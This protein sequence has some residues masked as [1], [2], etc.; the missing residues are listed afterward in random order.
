MRPLR[1]LY[2]HTPA[3]KFGPRRLKA[4][5]EEMVAEGLA[6]GRGLNRGY[7]NDHTGIIK[8]MFR[9]A[10]GEELVPVHV[11]QAL[12]T[13]DSIHK[14]RD[15][16]LTECR[17]VK[18]APRKHIRP[19]L[20]VVSPQIRTMV[21]LQLAT[22]MRPD[23]VTIMRPCDIDDTGEIWTYI[24]DSH[25]MDHK[26]LDRLVFL[27]PKAQK[28]LRPWLDRNAE[29]YLFSP[30]EVYEEAIAR[31]RKDPARANGRRKKPYPRMPRDHY[32]DETYCQAVE[33]ACR[34]AGVPKWTPGQLRHN[35]A[36]RIR[37]KY[38]LEAARVVLG[39]Q[40]ASTTEIYA[41]KDIAEALRIVSDLG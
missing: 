15:G 37:R 41:E 26:N 5:R 6:K 3:H 31:R 13:V 35:T 2:G 24:P 20:D 11:H 14:G 21:E 10:V 40:S 27:G 22:G 28:L 29:A 8:R 18:P 34:K 7:I 12:E 32:D 4:V 1:K 30:R 39:H 16:R 19:V 23:E 33:R 25:K 9:W 38:G 36:T 17:R